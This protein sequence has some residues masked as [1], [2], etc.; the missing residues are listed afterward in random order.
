M[1]YKQSNVNTSK[2]TN[3]KTPS[4]VQNYNRKECTNILLLPQKIHTYV[5][6]KMETITKTKILKNIIVAIIL[7]P[8]IIGFL[9]ICKEQI[10]D[11]LQ[12][13]T[14]VTT[15]FSVDKNNFPNIIFCSLKPY[16]AFFNKSS[17]TK[18]IYDNI[19]NSVDIIVS[20]KSNVGIIGYWIFF[21]Y[22]NKENNHSFIQ[23][24]KHKKK[25]Q[26]NYLSQLS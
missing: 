6:C 2:Y 5:T 18:D 3:K 24:L 14:S 1:K 23:I 10:N 4:L 7:C 8:C 22:Q 15:Q 9:W 19:T 26:I 25:L 20:I 16:K 12:G 17:V 21:I 13:F 11:Y